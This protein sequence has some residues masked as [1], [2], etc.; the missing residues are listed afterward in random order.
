MELDYWS[1]MDSQLLT[2]EE[3][4]YFYAGYYEWTKHRALTNPFRVDS[5]RATNYH[6]R[7]EEMVGASVLDLGC[8]PVSEARSLVHCATVH[9]VDPLVRYYEQLQPFG[10]EF[11]GSVGASRAEELPFANESVDV[12][13][14]RNMLDHSQNAEQVLRE[15]GR[16]LRPRGQL[17]LNC[18]IRGDLGGGLAHPYKWYREDF[19]ERVFAGF[20]PVTPVALLERPVDE[21]EDSGV[22]TTWVCRLRKRAR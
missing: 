17:L 5:T 19:E 9:A 11:F 21:V 3:K 16:T 20:D 7:P 8:G 10:W 13:H 18:D 15:I 12:V 22:V 6:M 14:C 1:S 4:Y 2:L